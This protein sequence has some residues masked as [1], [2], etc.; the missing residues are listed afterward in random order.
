MRRVRPF[1]IVLAGLVTLAVVVPTAAAQTGSGSSDL[2]AAGIEKVSA[3]FRD[4]RLLA[5]ELIGAMGTPIELALR[6]TAAASGNARGGGDGGPIID[7]VTE[8]TGMP[9]EH[10]IQPS[11]Q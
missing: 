3:G 4:L 8:E 1:A 6:S 9:P 5:M 7:G 10:P 11:N 2:I